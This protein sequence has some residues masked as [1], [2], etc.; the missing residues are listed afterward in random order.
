[1]R[2]KSKFAQTK[3]IQ[4]R[5]TKK[6]EDKREK[7]IA[8]IKTPKTM[9]KLNEIYISYVSLMYYSLLTQD[10]SANTI[11]GVVRTVLEH[12]LM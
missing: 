1:M 9:D 11:Q 3:K 7:Q 10:L 8:D 4:S 12:T 5:Y 2:K 6:T